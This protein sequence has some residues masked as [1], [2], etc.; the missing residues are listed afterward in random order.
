V[1]RILW[2]AAI[3]IIAFYLA[4]FKFVNGAPILVLV[5]A[6]PFVPVLDILFRAKKFEWTTPK[7]YTTQEK[8]F[9]Q[10]VYTRSFM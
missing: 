5:L 8:K 2:S 9:L 1:A 10:T 3:A 7:K 4:T 6:Q